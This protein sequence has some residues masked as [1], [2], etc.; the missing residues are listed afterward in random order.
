MIINRDWALNATRDIIRGT[1]GADLRALC[2]ED[3]IRKLKEAQEIATEKEA[4]LIA[5]P[6]FFEKK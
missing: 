5:K 3:E 2:T 1:D 6:T 4:W